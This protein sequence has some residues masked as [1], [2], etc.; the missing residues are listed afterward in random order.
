MFLRFEKIYNPNGTLSKINDL[1]CALYYKSIVLRDEL[2]R[3][4]LEN[5]LKQQYEI[6]INET[7]STINN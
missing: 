7:N 2:V 4:E 6:N 5:K 3:K 1:V